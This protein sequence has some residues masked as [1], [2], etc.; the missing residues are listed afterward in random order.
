[1]NDIKLAFRRLINAPLFTAVAVLTLA[2]GIGANSAVFSVVNGV[3]IRPL[4]YPDEGRLVTMNG[5]SSDGPT[6]FA[7]SEFLAMQRETRLVSPVAA[8]REW[9]FNVRA[10]D[11]PEKVDGAVV[12]ADFFKVIG[13]SPEIGRFPESAGADRLTTSEVVISD[14]YW[15]ASFGA[16][17]DILGKVVDVNG[18]P[19]SVVGVMPAGYDIPVG[20]QMWRPSPFS[21]PPHPLHPLEDPSSLNGT[22]YFE[23]IGRVQAG[24]SMPKALAEQNGIMKRIA[25][26]EGAQAE[27]DGAEL[28]TVHE[29]RVGESRPALLVLLGAAGVLLLI[30][31]VNLA[32]LLLARAATRSREWL[33]RSAL[34]AGR[35]QLAKE[36]LIESVMLSV[37]GG[38]AGLLVAIW[39]VASLRALA[40]FDLQSLIDPAPDWRV[41]TFTAVVSLVTGIAF[42]VAPVLQTAKN[43]LA[44]GIREGGRGAVDSRGRRRVRNVLAVSEVALACILAVGA[45]L[46]VKAFVR[47]QS[48]SEGFEPGGVVTMAITLPQSKY[49]DDARRAAFTNQV[50]TRIGALPG[51]TAAGAISRLPLNPGSSRSDLTVDG[52][53]QRPDDPSPDYL[54]A[55]PDYFKSLAI[56]VTRGRA[57]NERDLATAP[58]VA[59]VTAGTAQRFWGTQDVIGKRIKIRSDAWRE[60]VG[61]VAEVRQH[62]LD[63]SPIP[64]VY[65]PYAQDSWAFYTVAVHGGANAA[66]LVAPIERE[67]H[68]VDADQAVYNVRTMDEVVARSLAARRFMLTL[69]S[70]FSTIALILAA[71]GV[72]GVIAYGV[73]QRTREMGVRIA[74]GALPL[75]VVRLVVGDGMLMAGAGVVAGLTGAIFLAPVLQKML[76][77]VEPRDPATFIAVGG[78]VVAVALL[79][80]WIPARRAARVDP[81]EALREE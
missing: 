25:A 30:A 63:R 39:G 11:R 28:V 13:V 60:V 26:G 14:G 6:S 46:L 76:F 23:T 73:A 1:M 57:F 22:H 27:F 47:V 55:T 18:E 5:H 79:A 50:L 16:R 31:S 21:V 8:M 24:V 34:G 78:M 77:A 7:P 62:A 48:V 36:Q 68:A 80:S 54:V 52:R 2:L 66:S 17:A 4:P 41:L 53:E 64:A 69:I 3:L 35:W 42:G 71:V 70:L 45:G 20:V 51:V 19:V 37:M 58:P 40:P 33:V 29:D 72:Y 12:S 56:P 74:L 75:D 10:G 49:P 32:N 9:T 61:V 15:R 67:I 81:M 59:I 44:A 65:I 43:D 38:G